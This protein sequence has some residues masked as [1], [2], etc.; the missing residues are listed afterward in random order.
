MKIIAFL[1]FQN[2]IVVAYSIIGFISLVAYLP[3]IMALLKSKGSAKDLSLQTWFVWSLDALVSLF[4]AIFVLQD[5]IASIVFGV[6]FL[7]ALC[8][9]SL[10]SYNRMRGE[11]FNIRSV[12]IAALCNLSGN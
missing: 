10:A 8:I 7:G 3:Q 4:Y 6:D 12:R 2:S 1:T 5:L 9:L 11:G